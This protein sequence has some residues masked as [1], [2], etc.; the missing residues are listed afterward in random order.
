MLR[1][2]LACPRCGSAIAAEGTKFVCTACGASYPVRDGII[3][4][5][6][7]RR[8]YYFNPIP[9][10]AMEDLTRDARHAPWAN[11][12]RRFLKGVRQNPDWLDNLVADGRYAWKLL[13]R[14]PSNAHVLDLGCGLGNLTKN[15]AP[16]A[17]SVYA[18]DLTF[19]RLKF[20]QMRFEQFNPDDHI[21]LLAGGDGTSLPF[22]DESLDCVTLSGV[23][24]WVAD[25]S[26]AWERGNSRLE[27][28]MGAFLSFFGATNPRKI[29]LRFL[30]EI[31]RVLKPEGQLFIAIENRLSYRYF[32][33]RRDHHS[34]LWF[35]SLL[36]RFLANLYSTA[37]ARRP[38]RTYTYSING[39]RRLLSAAGFPRQEIYGLA[40]GYTHLAELIPLRTEKGLWRPPGSQG[41]NRIRRSRHFVPAYGIVASPQAPTGLSLAEKIAAAIE[42]QLGFKERSVFFTHFYTTGKAKG[43]I[44]GHAGDCPIVVKLPFNDSVIADAKNNHRFLQQAAQMEKLRELLPQALAAGKIQGMPYYVESRVEGQPLR[45]ELGK[46]NH[47]DVLKAV[48]GFLQMLNS[49]LHEQALEELSGEFYQG[50]VSLP[51][52]QV[53]SALEA[54]ALIEKA[55]AYFRD[56]LYGLRV[57]RGRVHGDFSTSNIFIQEFQISGVIDWDN[58]DFL[59]IPVLDALNY[60]ESAYRYLNA[61]MSLAQTIPLLAHKER[62]D[63]KEQQFLEESYHH[64]GI[65]SS[66]HVAFVSLYW[67]RH[68]AQQLN[69]GLIYNA[70]ALEERVTA[71]LKR[72]LKSHPR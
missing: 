39:Y 57:R 68:V 71:V 65:D 3:D 40:P 33:G 30:S 11:T 24:E 48:S 29:Q 43:V 5:R 14:L 59:G 23:L 66:H 8:D 21:V 49:D 37:V 70:P 12:V 4:F 45:A 47:T 22:P 20:A 27:K 50:Q 52:E 10:E 16:S 51:L 42:S 1:E 32:G 46:Q 34:G 38:Y 62:L 58:A 44:K 25:D 13:L 56:Q 53:A 2:D 63:K 28:A 6:C 17:D 36:P 72:L 15:I 55:Q 9:R 35:A 26:S 18:L 61:E 7:H 41:L 54:P 31:R 67:L 64:C 69:E 60:L 19:E